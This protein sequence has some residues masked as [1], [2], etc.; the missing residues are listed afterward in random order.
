MKFAKSIQAMTFA[1]IVA[2]S[3]LGAPILAESAHA[4][5]TAGGQGD[6][7]GGDI[8]VWDIIESATDEQQEDDGDVA[9]TAMDEI[10]AEEETEESIGQPEYKYVSVRRF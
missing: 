7:G 6:G 4:Q 8:I 9:G 2:A 10:V 5:R 3:M 1:A